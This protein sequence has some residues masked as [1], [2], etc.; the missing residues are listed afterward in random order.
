MG[1]AERATRDENLRLKS[2]YAQQRKRQL[3]RSYYEFFID[4]WDVLEPETGLKDNWHIKFLCD[5]IQWRVERVAN[6]L[7]K[8]NDLIVNEP[9]RCGKS[10]L[11]S[12]LLT[13]WAWTR[14]PWMKFM[15]SSYDQNLSND[16]NVKARRVIE[17]AWYQEKWGNVFALTGDQN[18]KRFFENDKRGHRIAVS[19]SSEA[20]IA[21]KGCDVSV[22]DDDLDVK[23]WRSA[24]KRKKAKEHVLDDLPKRINDKAVGIQIIVHQRLHDDDPTGAALKASKDDFDHISIPSED[25]GDV[26][27]PGLKANYRDGLFF[28]AHYSLEV[29]RKIQKR[30]AVDYAA[31][32]LQKPGSAGGVTFPRDAWKFY[33]ILPDR[34]EKLMFSWDMSYKKTDDASYTVGQL[35]GKLDG[36]AYLVHQW[37]KQCAFR[38]AKAAV[39]A[40]HLQYPKARTIKIENKANGPAILDSLKEEISTLIEVE[41]EGS[42]LERA[43][44][45]ADKVDLGL[46]YL[47]HPDLQPWVLDFIE[48]FVILDPDDVFDQ[49]D[50]W[51]QAMDDLF[52]KNDVAQRIRELLGEKKE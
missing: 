21:G 34:F 6:R 48:E 49:V 24:T 3:E 15:G 37:R 51:S 43:E 12:I 50:A 30:N 27:P 20:G 36:K 45:H 4:G 32:C 18:E 8:L 23:G 35:W 29:C 5:E 38:E 14:W 52:G 41:P 13:P 9:P 39:K 19:A 33:K 22:S 2:I 26:Q 1:T 31:Q 25:T 28:P 16:Y 42:K 11:F 17:S 46:V 7:P 40:L 47:P 44:A 10:L